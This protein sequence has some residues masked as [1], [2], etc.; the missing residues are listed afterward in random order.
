MPIVTFA[1]KR[2]KVAIPRGSHDPEN[3]HFPPVSDDACSLGSEMPMV[4]G[5]ERC[6]TTL[7]FPVSE[8][9]A[10]GVKIAPK[11]QKRPLYVIRAS[12]PLF[13]RVYSSF[14]TSRTIS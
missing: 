6:R 10:K 1:V 11:G 14:Y 5:H 2:S 9:F 4:G 3:V 13:L 12:F 7:V 8:L